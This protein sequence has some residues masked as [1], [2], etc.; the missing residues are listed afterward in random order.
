M[1][2]YIYIECT[3]FLSRWQSSALF[4]SLYP[5]PFLM[6][7]EYCWP[8]P[9]LSANLS[10]QLSRKLHFLLAVY[11][12]A[13]FHRGTWASFSRKRKKNWEV[14][15]FSNTREGKIR[16]FSLHK[17]GHVI[18]RSY[19]RIEL[20]PCVQLKLPERYLFFHRHSPALQKMYI[21][22]SMTAYTGSMTVSHAALN[23]CLVSV[24]NSIWSMDLASLAAARQPQ[25]SQHA[26]AAK[27]MCSFQ[28]SPPACLPAAFCWDTASISS[29]P[30]SYHMSWPAR[31]AQGV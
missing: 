18:S 31:G 20:M 29:L 6:Y 30:P 13:Y 19:F 9:F 22:G 24:W 25:A 17:K 4:S 10:S 11:T 28:A 15:I 8:L 14:H 27:M 7:A 21:F 5:H 1:N 16:S 2:V 26:S 12:Q 3:V 23:H